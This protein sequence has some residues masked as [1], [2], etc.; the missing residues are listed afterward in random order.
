METNRP[1]EAT[2]E[3]SMDH[4]IASIRNVR[5]HQID[6]LMKESV[7]VAF[8]EHYYDTVVISNVKRAFLFKDLGELKFSS[9]D[10]AHYSSLIAKMK[11]TKSLSV[12]GHNPLFLTELKNIFQKH[13]SKK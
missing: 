4:I 12:N 13:V 1:S 5:N 9:L 3:L 7:L 8:L 11:E 6:E 10:L 2:I